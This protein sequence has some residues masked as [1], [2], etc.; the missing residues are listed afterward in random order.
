MKP[1]S[2][3]KDLAVCAEQSDRDARWSSEMLAW[4]DSRGR[5][6]TSLNSDEQSCDS[7][8][9][10]RISRD[11]SLALRQIASSEG[12]SVGVYLREM[13][14]SRVLAKTIQNQGR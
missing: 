4:D 1:S 2:E 5:L 7:V 12:K 8:V 9:S 6:I 13:I 11:V 14:N 3:K 10:C